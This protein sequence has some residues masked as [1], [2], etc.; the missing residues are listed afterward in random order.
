MVTKEKSKSGTRPIGS[1]ESRFELVRVRF[2]VSHST[3]TV[4]DSLREAKMAPSAFGRRKRDAKPLHCV[5]IVKPSGQSHS[6]AMAGNYSPRAAITR[7]GA[8]MRGQFQ[9]SPD[10]MA[11]CSPGIPER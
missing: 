3:P 9:I 5:D 10:S 7:F 11:T 8:G 6:P 2:L 1:K 4:R